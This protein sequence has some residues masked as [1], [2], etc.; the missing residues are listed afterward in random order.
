VITISKLN[1]AKDYYDHGKYLKSFVAVLEFLGREPRNKK[2]LRLKADLCVVIGKLPEAIEACQIYIS[3]CE[4][5]DQFWEKCYS[6]R[7]IGSAY[8]QLKNPDLSMAYYQKLLEEYERFY[9]L[10]MDEYSEPVILTLLTIGGHQTILGKDSEAIATYEKLLRL[11]SKHGPLEGIANSFYEIGRIYYQQNDLAKAL[12]KFLRAVSIYETLKESVS[13]GHG[14][15]YLGCIFFVR[16]EF[17]KSLTHFNS[18]ITYL[19]GFYAGIYDEAN[20][21]DDPFYRR[22]VRLRECLRKES[23]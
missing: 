19:E 7:M 8:W 10:G 15:Y 11:Y 4:G 2:A 23:L 22:A 18:S 21:E 9:D 12:P 13:Y 20:A 14:H 16:K 1:N 17:T 5:D 6:L 3:L